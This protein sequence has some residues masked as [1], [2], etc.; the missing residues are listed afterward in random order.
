MC[1][2]LVEHTCD[3]NPGGVETG[4]SDGLENLTRETGVTAGSHVH[5]RCSVWSVSGDFSVTVSN[6]N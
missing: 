3:P 4:T 6:G 2:G 1:K 5:F